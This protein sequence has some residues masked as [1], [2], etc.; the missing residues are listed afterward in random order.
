MLMDEFTQAAKPEF[1]AIVELI[2]AAIKAYGY[3][4]DQ[5]VKW[6]Q[7]TYAKDGDFHHWICAIK[8]TKNFVG[9]TFHFGGLFDDPA[10][11]FIVGTSKFSRK[12]E[13]RQ[14]GEVD[15]GVI[16][17]FIGQ[18]LDKLEYFKANWQEIQKGG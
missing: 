13:Y 1:K 18:A 11:L 17:D 10:G 15:A 7:L 9:L 14:P 6:G 4:L 5:A 12:I 16:Q 2:D 8:V 3:S